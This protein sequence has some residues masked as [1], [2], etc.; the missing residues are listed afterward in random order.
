MQITVGGQALT[1]IVLAAGTWGANAAPLAVG[2]HDVV[3]SITDNAHNVGTQTQTLTITDSD[4][5][6]LV[7]HYQPDAAIAAR[8]GA[9]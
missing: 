9:S 1:A 8:T 2:P 4:T 5:T 7:T 6:W 3:A